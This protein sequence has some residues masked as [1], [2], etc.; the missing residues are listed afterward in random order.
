MRMLLLTLSTAAT[1]T[2]LVRAPASSW[3]VTKGHVEA[4]S[5]GRARIR[6]PKLRAVVP[7]SDGDAAELRFVYEGAT[8][9]VA[10]LASGEVRR[11]IGL[12]LRA[13]DGCN[14]VYVMWR[15]EPKAQLVVSVKR[16]PGKRTHREC[17]AN[18]YVN[19][20]PRAGSAPSMPVT[21][22]AEH[23]LHAAIDGRILRVWADRT[24][25][26]EGELPDNALD[27]RGPAGVRSDNGAFSVELLT[28]AA[29]SAWTPA[30]AGDDED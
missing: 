15:I 6:E 17:G 4:I 12:K 18:G 13:A 1:L 14:L 26:W 8:A 20:K 7:G 25:A 19:L 10:P 16:N 30:V 5:D 2:A 11:Q 22:G 29:T 21:V 24:L 28:R 27:L 23:R 9:G 3:R